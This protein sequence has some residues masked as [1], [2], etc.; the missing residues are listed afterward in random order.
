[1][2]L[3]P[4]TSGVSIRGKDSGPLSRPGKARPLSSSRVAY[5]FG[6]DEAKKGIAKDNVTTNVLSP[7]GATLLQLVHE[8]AQEVV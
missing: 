3:V 4:G 8:V 5:R 2:H 7:Y 1:M 6:T